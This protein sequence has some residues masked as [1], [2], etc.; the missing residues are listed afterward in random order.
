MVARMLGQLGLRYLFN[1]SCCSYIVTR[2]KDYL[3]LEDKPIL[4]SAVIMTS[5]KC[6]CAQN[7]ADSGRKTAQNSREDARGCVPGLVLEPCH[8]LSSKWVIW[9]GFKHGLS[10]LNSH[11]ASTSDTMQAALLLNMIAVAF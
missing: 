2:E 6:M 10:C 11:A 1:S 4:K 8:L 3:Q 5:H 7:K 9:K